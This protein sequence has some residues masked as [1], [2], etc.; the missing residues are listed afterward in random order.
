MTKTT[1]K[2]EIEKKTGSLKML[3][4]AF[5]EELKNFKI[6]SYNIMHQYKQYRKCIENL[7]ERTVVVHIDFSENY[8]CKLAT[9]IQAMHFDGS[10]QQISL[11]TGVLYT[12]KGYRSFASLSP[13]SIFHVE[14]F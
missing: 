10:R 1:K 8:S 2:N 6:H 9:E 11:H 5:Q 3:L 4:D 12:K 13:F 14:L 7:D